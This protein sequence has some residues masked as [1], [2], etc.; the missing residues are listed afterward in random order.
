MGNLNPRRFTVQRLSR[1][2]TLNGQDCP[3]AVHLGLGDSVPKIARDFLPTRRPEARALRQEGSSSGPHRQ[4]GLGG[5]LLT[6]A[7]A[8]FYCGGLFCL[9][10]LPP[11]GLAVPRW[12]ILAYGVGCALLA[13]R[14]LLLSSKEV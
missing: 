4:S 13:V 2:L 9:A 7:S 6:W 3:D 11:C 10:V 8:L 14:A 12:L 5:Y 1:A